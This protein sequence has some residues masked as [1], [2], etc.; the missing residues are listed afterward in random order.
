V[1][2][3][4]SNDLQYPYTITCLLANMAGGEDGEGGFNLQVFSKDKSMSMKKLN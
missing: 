3:S 4:A 2:V 1:K